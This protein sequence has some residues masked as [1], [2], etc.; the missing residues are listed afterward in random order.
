MRAGAGKR[1]DPTVP[2]HSSAHNRV[3]RAEL[4]TLEPP[5]VAYVANAAAAL[6]NFAWFWDQ[7]T[8]P[9]EGNNKILR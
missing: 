3:L 8:D 4:A 1:Q 7:E 9:S 6:A 5:I 2:S